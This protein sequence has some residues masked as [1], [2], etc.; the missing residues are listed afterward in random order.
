MYFYIEGTI[1]GSG[2]SGF[3]LLNGRGR[4][5]KSLEPGAY[6]VKIYDL[7]AGINEYYAESKGFTVPGM[8]N[9]F[10]MIVN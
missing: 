6:K 2:N 3:S 1:S 5:T 4:I 7:H 8:F 10:Y 9:I